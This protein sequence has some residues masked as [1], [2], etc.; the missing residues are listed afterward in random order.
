MSLTVRSGGGMLDCSDNVEGAMPPTPELCKN[1]DAFA[2]QEASLRQHHIGKVVVFH[3]GRFVDAFDTV[4]S[5]AREA[6]RRF[7]RQ[8]FLI[9][10][11][12]RPTTMPMPASVAWPRVHATG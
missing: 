4:D 11:V 5:A 7:G 1:I 10:E 9:R 12:G 2:A 8:T 6:I 3:D